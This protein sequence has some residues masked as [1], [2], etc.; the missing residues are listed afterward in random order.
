MFAAY[1][2]YLFRLFFDLFS[3]SRSLSLGVNMPLESPRVRHLL[4]SCSQAWQLIPF[5]MRMLPSKGIVN[6]IN[7]VE[8][9]TNFSDLKTKVI[10][11]RGDRKLE[12]DQA[13]FFLRPQGRIKWAIRILSFQIKNNRLAHLPPGVGVPPGQSLIRHWFIKFDTRDT[14]YEIDNVIEHVVY[15]PK[16]VS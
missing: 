11:Q 5:Q 2:F 16:G 3:L 9:T 14:Q 15:I 6:V 7:L 8:T 4:T 12:G 10:L 1:F 13:A